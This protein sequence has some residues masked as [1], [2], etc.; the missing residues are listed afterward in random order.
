MVD[1]WIQN[2][3]KVKHWK[4]RTS[5]NNYIIWIYP[6]ASNSHHQDNY[7]FSRESLYNNINLYLALESWAARCEGYIQYTI[8]HENRAELFF[9]RMPSSWCLHQWMPHPWRRKK[10]GWG[11]RSFRACNWS[12]Q[13]PKPSL[14]AVYI[15]DYTTQWCRFYTIR[16]PMNQSVQWN[17]IR[18]LNQLLI[19]QLWWCKY[20]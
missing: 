9:A 12:G 17:V 10:T 11:R 7:I 16:I 18:V 6:P 2:A 3:K 15:R 14:V 20:M 13:L 19:L 5:S 4:M 1:S 8:K